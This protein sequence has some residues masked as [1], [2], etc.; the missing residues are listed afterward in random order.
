MGSQNTRRYFTQ[1]NFLRSW[2]WSLGEHRQFLTLAALPHCSHSSLKS[3]TH[4]N[5]WCP[6][7]CL[8]Y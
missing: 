7:G 5:W 8:D 6:C 1:L 4:R 3:I 2:I